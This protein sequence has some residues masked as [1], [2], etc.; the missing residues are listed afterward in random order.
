[1][2]S[3]VAVVVGGAGAPEDRDDSSDCAGDGREAQDR[4]VRRA[5]HE[6]VEDRQRPEPVCRP[7]HDAPDPVGEPSRSSDVTTTAMP[8]SN[9]MV[10]SPIQNGS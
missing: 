8:M 1:M 5:E 4:L 7:V 10:P 9:A 6:A 3:S 2:A